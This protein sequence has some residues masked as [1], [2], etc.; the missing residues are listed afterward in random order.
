MPSMD[1]REHLYQ[2][3]LSC[4][5]SIFKKCR[6][7]ECSCEWLVNTNSDDVFCQECTVI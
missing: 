3:S 7:K 6:D 2:A 1:A 4:A 5:T